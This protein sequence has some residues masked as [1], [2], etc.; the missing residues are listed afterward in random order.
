M[1]LKTFLKGDKKEM[2]KKKNMVVPKTSP[3]HNNPYTQYL[4]SAQR[5]SAVV[6][7]TRRLLRRNVR[8]PLK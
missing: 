3:H 1:N 4:V 2:G 5:T 6:R 7:A 8:D